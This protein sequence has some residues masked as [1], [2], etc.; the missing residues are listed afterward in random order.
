MCCLGSGKPLV[1]HLLST[2]PTT[3][4]IYSALASLA[5]AADAEFQRWWHVHM[6][7]LLLVTARCSDHLVMAYNRPLL[8]AVCGSSSTDQVLLIFWFR[9]RNRSLRQPVMPSPEQ[10]V[11]S[12]LMCLPVLYPT[13]FHVPRQANS[14]S[15]SAELILDHRITPGI[16]SR[17]ESDQNEILVQ[18]ALYTWRASD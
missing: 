2:F 11:S 5:G 10:Q 15:V 8:L 7:V 12:R 4:Q 1:L 18:P 16:N 17:Q 9:P 14:F 13:W 3:A 6:C